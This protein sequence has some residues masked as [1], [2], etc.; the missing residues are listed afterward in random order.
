MKSFRR[1]TLERRRR[2]HAPKYFARDIIIRLTQ[3]YVAIRL[4]RDFTSLCVSLLRLFLLTLFK[5]LRGIIVIKILLFTVKM[6]EIKKERESN[7]YYID[8]TN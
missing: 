7:Y 5:V 1:S 4:F 6:T 3:K 8:E 2:S